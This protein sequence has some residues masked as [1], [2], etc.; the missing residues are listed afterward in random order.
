[1]KSRAA[2]AI[3]PQLPLEIAEIDVEGPKAGEV[4]IEIFASGV[5]HTDAHTLSGNDALAQFPAILGHEGAGIVREIGPGVTSV[6][7]G[8]HVIP[9]FIPECRVCRACTSHRTNVCTA[10]EATQW[11]GL[12][13]DGTKRFSDARGPIHHYIGCSTFTNFTVVPEI[14]VAK[15]RS[16]APLDKVCYLGCGV[17]TGIGAAINTAQVWPGA[18]VVVFGLGGI[19]L[20]V[21]QGARL[22]GAAKII[23]VDLNDAKRDIAFKF[24]ITDFV[25]PD[26]VGRDKLVQAI[27]DL[28]QGGADFAFECIGNIAVMR[29][30]FASVQPAWGQLIIIGVP[31]SA[32]A[33]EIAPFELLMGKRIYGTAFG[34][35]RGRTQL[36]DIVDWYMD[37]R[38]N[39]DDLITHTMPI[40]RINHAFDLMHRGESI[41]S[42]VI[43]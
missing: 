20:N 10:T 21:V 14:A 9:L 2:I 8:D 4:L 7:V 1:M 36:P 30:A 5:C 6:A 28:T 24:G 38:I 32:A 3:G 15:I 17:T 16:D 12:M 42:V 31:P 25:N 27:K 39:V 29:D 23:G 18:T 33:L 37:G 26:T 40:E 22:A 34:G 41:R 13:P 11:I 19:G 35:V 43:F